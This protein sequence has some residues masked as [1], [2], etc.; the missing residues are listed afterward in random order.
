MSKNANPEHY[1]F[2]IFRGACPWTPLEGLKKFF[3]L[4]RGSK[5]FLGSTTTPNK[6]LHRTL[7]ADTCVGNP[8]N[9]GGSG[10]GGN[11]NAVDGSVETD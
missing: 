4:L 5:N 1:L 11:W 6:I 9:Q 2:K 8:C 7:E 10:G 3:W